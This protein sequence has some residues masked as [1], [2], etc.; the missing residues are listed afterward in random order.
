MM[1]KISVS[2]RVI[3]LLTAIAAGTKIVTGMEHHSIIST[4]YYTVAFGVLVLA[5]IMLLLFG[6]TLLENPFMPIV[7]TLI[8]MMLSLGLVQDYIPAMVKS[9]TLLMGL[10]YLISIYARFKAT[11]RTAS[12]ILAVVH[13]ISGLLLVIM[14]HILYFWYGLPARILFV[15]IGGLVIGVQ[16]TLLAVQKLDI[17]K[18]DLNRLL[19]FF[20]GMLLIS[21]VGFITGLTVD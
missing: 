20:P 10:L 3:F 1:H 13:A 17:V 9:Y 2:D 19:S 18:I 14:P 11:P 12:L 4:F 5:S 7:S 8:P 15:S 16:G 21:T 6:F